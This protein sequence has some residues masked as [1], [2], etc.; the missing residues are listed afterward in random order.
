MQ[1]SLY[2][3][4]KVFKIVKQQYLYTIFLGNIYITLIL[5]HKITIRTILFSQYKG[6]YVIEFGTL[7]YKLCKYYTVN[8]VFSIRHL[9]LKSNGSLF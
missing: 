1:Y 4:F 6:Q 3:L 7:I 8:G 5:Y 9:N 2:V